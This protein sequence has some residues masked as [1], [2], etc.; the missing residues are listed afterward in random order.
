MSKYLRLAPGADKTVFLLIFVSGVACRSPIID[1]GANIL[2][3]AQ[4]QQKDG[5]YP[6]Q[7]IL[8]SKRKRQQGGDVEKQM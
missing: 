5:S 2:D 6:K 4:I 3:I 1:Q 8:P 7:L